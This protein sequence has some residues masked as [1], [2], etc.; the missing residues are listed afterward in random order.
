MTSV[1]LK[2]SCISIKH[3]CLFKGGSHGCSPTTEVELDDA[4]PALRYLKS[5][6]DAHGPKQIKI[7]VSDS[8][9]PDQKHTQTEN[10]DSDEPDQKYIKIESSDSD[11]P[12]SKHIKIGTLLSST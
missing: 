3:Y 11:A 5:A 6:S 12:N 2:Q 8:D 9:A 10:S 7:E 4:S 1:K